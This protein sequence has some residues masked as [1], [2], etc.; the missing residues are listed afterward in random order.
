MFIPYVPPNQKG[1]NNRRKINTFIAVQ[2]AKKRR[3]ESKL[4]GRMEIFWVQQT[5]SS[6]QE[7]Q[8]EEEDKRSSEN[9]R[10]VGNQS[11]AELAALMRSPRMPVATGKFYPI[12]NGWL[13]IGRRPTLDFNVILP[14]DSKALGHG[15]SS[16]ANFYAS[17]LL[18]WSNTCDA[19]LH[20]LTAFTLCNLEAP[21]R[22]GIARAATLFHRR[23]LFNA[24]TDMLSRQEVNDFLIQAICLLI[25][26][27]DYLGPNINPPLASTSLISTGYLTPAS[28]E[29]L[30]SFSSWLTAHRGSN[31]ALIPVWRYSTTYPLTPLERCLFTALL[32]LADDLSGMGVHP[33]AIIFRQP[34]KRAEMLLAV[35]ELWRDTLLADLLLWMA[36]VITTPR[37]PEIPPWAV[38]RELFCG[39]VSARRDL[40]S[41]SN[42]GAALRCF[43]YE[44]ARA[45][46][47]KVTWNAYTMSS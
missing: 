36:M 42:V 23:K 29:I 47:W 24:V 10:A 37:N 43:F 1:G 18:N 41:W 9:Q 16:S 38:Q 46:F 2:A 40:E 11:E 32:C 26:I 27:D 8:E 19:I 44:E 22:T 6:L 33:A 5:Q 12:N 15:S 20:G 13:L 28:T 3:K 21:D 25:P 30:L 14:H 31:P 17:V 45:P 34:E 39:I 35:R 7:E 4:T